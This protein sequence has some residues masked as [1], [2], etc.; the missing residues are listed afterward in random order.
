M[1]GKIVL[2]KN[3]SSGNI[4]W[5]KRTGIDP[6]GT[7]DDRGAVEEV[8]HIKFSLFITRQIARPARPEPICLTCIRTVLRKARLPSANQNAELVL[9]HSSRGVSQMLIIRQ[10]YRTH[11][12][13]TRNIIAE[14]AVLLYLAGK[15]VHVCCTV[16][17]EDSHSTD[18]CICLSS[19]S[20]KSC[21]KIF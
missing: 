21:E 5:E 13:T 1:K 12:I 7:P 4:Y 3:R 17:W 18:N 8:N 9:Q 14:A 20:A 19:L 10:S 16:N 6:C 15:H 2:S 11:I